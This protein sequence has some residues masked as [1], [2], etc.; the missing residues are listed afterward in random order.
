MKSEPNPF[1]YL[2]SIQID[3]MKRS[4]S[5]ELIN[6]LTKQVKRIDSAALEVICQLSGNHVEFLRTV[7]DIWSKALLQSFYSKAYN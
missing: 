1:L 2:P 3:Y 5:Q 7:Q 4:P 6:Y